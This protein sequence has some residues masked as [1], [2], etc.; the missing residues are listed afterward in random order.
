MLP[1]IPLDLIEEVNT[2]DKRTW[3]YQIEL[4]STSKVYGAKEAN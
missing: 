1:Q 4:Y 3:W 2:K